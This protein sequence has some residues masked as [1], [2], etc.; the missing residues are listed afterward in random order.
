MTCIAP[1]YLNWQRRAEHE[2]IA[3]HHLPI[4]S[5][6]KLDQ[7]EELLVMVEEQQGDPL[8]PA[9]SLKCRKSLCPR[10]SACFHDNSTATDL[11]IDIAAKFGLRLVSLA[12]ADWVLARARQS[13]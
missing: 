3:V 5:D 11:A 12:R 2:V 13:G 8:V 4:T 1:N 10:T 7:E 9:R 6:T